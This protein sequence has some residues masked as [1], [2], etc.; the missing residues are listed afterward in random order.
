MIDPTAFT[1]PIQNALS[2]GHPGRRLQRRRAA[3]AASPT[4]ART[5]SCPASRWASTSWR[6]CPAAATSRCSS[7]RRA[8]PTSSRAST[9][10]SRRSRRT[11]R[12]ST[13]VVATG[14]AVPQELS[15]IESFWPGPHE[16]QGHVRGRRRQHAELLQTIQK[17]GLKGKVKWRRLRP[18][19]DHRAAARTRATASSRSTSSPTCRASCRSSSCTCTRPRK[20][21][22][23]VAD[24]DT[25][26]K[27]LD[28]TTAARTQ[29]EEPLRGHQHVARAS[30]RRAGRSAA[31]DSAGCRARPIRARRLKLHRGAL[32][33]AARP[34]VPLAAHGRCSSGS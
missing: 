18:D 2:E 29:H 28:P 23:G 24:V 22:T 33:S 26:L 31:V 12:S 1:A 25:G 17:H 21:L 5:C 27:F 8:R 13:H 6:C 19:A 20:G 3:T 9:A 34:P 32:R 15:T 14:A 11:Q 10:P 30:R 16:L 4:S 7:R